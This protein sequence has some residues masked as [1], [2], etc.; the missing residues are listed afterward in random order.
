MQLCR[1]IA[2]LDLVEVTTRS[3]SGSMQRLMNVP[4]KVHNPFECIRA[5]QIGAS[6]QRSTLHTMDAFTQYSCLVRY[7]TDDAAAFCAI[8]GIIQAAAMWWR[9]MRV[10]PVPLVREA[11]FCCVRIRV[12]P[13]CGTAHRAVVLG[14]EYLCECGRGLWSEEGLG[15][16][17]YLH[18]HYE[19]VSLEQPCL[20]SWCRVTICVPACSGDKQGCSV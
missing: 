20:S 17:A 7:R 15:D 6:A 10:Y 3:S 1:N 8:T 12:G 5:R 13:G 9:I 16:E 18:V 14:F 4:E 2:K 11:A 19:G